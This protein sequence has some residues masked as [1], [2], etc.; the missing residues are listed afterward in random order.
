MGNIW[1]GFKKFLFWAYERGSWQYDV[2]CA[3][4]LAFIFFGPNQVFHSADG[5]QAAPV[6]VTVKEVG[7]IEEGAYDQTLSDFISRKYNR[8]VRA[9]NIEPLKDGEGHL[10]GYLVNEIK[11]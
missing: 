6:F 9:R 4:I 3:V 7:I 11:Q 2:L 8:K 10:K 1:Y 5:N